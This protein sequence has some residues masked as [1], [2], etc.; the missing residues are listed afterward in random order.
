MGMSLQVKPWE[1]TPHLS[2][3]NPKVSLICMNI[4]SDNERAGQRVTGPLEWFALISIISS[5][6][7]KPYPVFTSTGAHRTP[8]GR[9]V[10]RCHLCNKKTDLPRLTPLNDS[11]LPRCQYHCPAPG[12]KC[13]E[14][15]QGGRFFSGIRYLKIKFKINVFFWKHNAFQ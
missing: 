10:E 9:S 13:E 1:K 7:I 4:S 2:P 14:E 11:L 12:L 15:R 5:V 6:S 8:E 3:P